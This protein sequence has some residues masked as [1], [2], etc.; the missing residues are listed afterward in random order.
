MRLSSQQEGFKLQKW[1]RKS[2]IPNFPKW[3]PAVLDNT[4]HH[5]RLW[6]NVNANLCMTKWGL[7]D[8]KTAHRI[9]NENNT[10]DLPVK[11]T[12]NWVKQ[13][14]LLKYQ[15]YIPLCCQSKD[16]Q[17]R[18]KVTE[19]NGRR[20]TKI[21]ASNSFSIGP[22]QKDWRKSTLQFKCF[23]LHNDEL[24]HNI[25]C[26]AFVSIV[27]HYSINAFSNRP[28]AQYVHRPLPSEATVHM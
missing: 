14:V 13:T 21:R 17:V 23:I 8:C 22:D 6:S 28:C 7:S 12:C 24:K 5:N 26:A 10:C 4:S 25:M 19:N 27:P 16:Q 3:C 11:L 18:L 1:L 9:L 15:H 2:L 20:V